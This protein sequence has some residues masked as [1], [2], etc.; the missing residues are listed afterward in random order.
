MVWWNGW[1]CLHVIWNTLPSKWRVRECVSEDD[2]MA[3]SPMAHRIF[4]AIRIPVKNFKSNFCARFHLVK[5]VNV[6]IFWMEEI[7]CEM[8]DIDIYFCHFLPLNLP[9]DIVGCVPQSWISQ[10]HNTFAW[11]DRF[12]CHFPKRMTHWNNW[13]FWI[14]KKAQ[15]TF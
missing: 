1:W 13:H 11:I 2:K 14:V 12:T 7:L 6:F 3:A 15:K 9:K 4:Q 10:S 8:R 5:I